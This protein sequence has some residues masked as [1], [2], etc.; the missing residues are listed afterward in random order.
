M[1]IGGVFLHS[2]FSTM[3]KPKIADEFGPV[4]PDFVEEN[5]SDSSIENK[6]NCPQGLGQNPR[7][8]SNRAKSPQ[9]DGIIRVTSEE[10]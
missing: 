4:E 2:D 1:P 9:C 3:K 10:R 7:L 6:A 5:L 8:I